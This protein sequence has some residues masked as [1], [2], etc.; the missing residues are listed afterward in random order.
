MTDAQLKAAQ[1]LADALKTHG[2]CACDWTPIRTGDKPAVK[3]RHCL[4]LQQW[5]AVRPS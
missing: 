4:A 3:C 1:S 2:R 5:E